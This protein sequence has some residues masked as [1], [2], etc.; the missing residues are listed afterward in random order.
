MAI[1]TPPFYGVRTGAWFLATLD[2]VTIDTNMHPCDENGDPIEG[3]YLTGNDSGGFFSV[4]YPNL[5]TGARLRAHHDLRPPRRHAGGNRAGVRRPRL[6]G[7]FAF[8]SRLFRN[9]R[10][11]FVKP[12]PRDT[13]GRASPPATSGY[14]SEPPVPCG[15]GVFACRMEGSAKERKGATWKRMHCRKGKPLVRVRARCF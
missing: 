3:L 12:F 15:Q 1:D 9:P 2:G 5:L 8:A 7:P 6:Q 14:K 10:R 13:A 11:Q 4:S